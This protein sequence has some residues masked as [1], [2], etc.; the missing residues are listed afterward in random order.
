MGLR[1]AVMW[2]GCGVLAFA[3]DAADPPAMAATTAR[4]LLE[5]RDVSVRLPASWNTRGSLGLVVGLHSWGNDAKGLAQWL[6]LDDLADAH[7]V[8]LAFPNGSFDPQGRRFWNATDA[9]CDFSN[10]GVDDLGHLGAMLDTLEQMWPIDPRR[11]WV[12]GHSNGAFMA[13]RLA[14][15]LADRIAG[16]AA[17]EAASFADPARCSPTSPVAVANIHG[18][19]DWAIRYEGGSV[20]P[21]AP[22]YPGAEQTVDAW[23]RDDGC[24]GTLQDTGDVVSIDAERG[25]TG[26]HVLAFTG[27]RTAVELWRIDGG[28]HIPVPTPEL[29]ARILDFFVRHPKP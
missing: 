14:C 6:A 24:S 27:C 29:S 12:V 19:D 2:I 4:I 10:T 26:A 8:V 25:A 22:P 23:A 16:I 15:D 3:C 20:Y 21:G 7:G 9:C 13:F 18:T 28:G 1:A 17:I 11:V 5:G